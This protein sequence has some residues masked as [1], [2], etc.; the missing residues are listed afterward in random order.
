MAIFLS[1]IFFLPDA[2]GQNAQKVPS[3]T[4][5]LSGQ[6]RLV[7]P[8]LCDRHDY[9]HLKS[10]CEM[11]TFELKVFDRWGNSVFTSDSWAVNGFTLAGGAKGKGSKHS[12]P[13]GTYVFVIN[14]KPKGGSE[15]VVNG[16]VTI[17]QFME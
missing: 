4:I 12:F 11:E 5:E 9:W 17:Q 8:K 15:Q 10:N 13:D 7:I 2:N 16:S 1:A 14:L 3:D 6:C